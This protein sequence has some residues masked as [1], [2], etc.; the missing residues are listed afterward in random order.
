MP[1]AFYDCKHLLPEVPPSGGGATSFFHAFHHIIDAIG[2]LLNDGT[3][4]VRVVRESQKGQKRE[5]AGA[6]AVAALTL[7]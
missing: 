3:V 7:R 1:G 6:G 4:P 5:R 2:V